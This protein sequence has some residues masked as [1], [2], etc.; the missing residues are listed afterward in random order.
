MT[1]TNTAAET[2]HAQQQSAELSATERARWERD[3]FFTREQVFTA[4]EVARL[5]AAL[6]S[7]AARVQ[8]AANASDT[9]VFGARGH[10]VYYNAVFGA[11]ALRN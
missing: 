5:S 8:Q 3:G 6:E 10:P 7:V 4:P 11:R 1:T 2:K 9:P